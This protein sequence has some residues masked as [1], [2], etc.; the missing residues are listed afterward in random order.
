MIQGGE[1]YIW[2][3][4]GISWGAMLL[5]TWSLVRRLKSAQQE[6]QAQAFEKEQA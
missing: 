6:E 5:Y 3:A 2:S 4:Y 1:E